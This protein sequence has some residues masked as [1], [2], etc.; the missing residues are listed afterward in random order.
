MH[1]THGLHVDRNRLEIAIRTLPTELIE[2]YLDQ[3]IRVVGRVRGITPSRVGKVRIGVSWVRGIT[4]ASVHRR[5]MTP[6]HRCDR[7]EAALATTVGSLPSP[8]VVP[9][10]TCSVAW[11]ARVSLGHHWDNSWSRSPGLSHGVAGDAGVGAC[12]SQRHG[13]CSYEPRR[14]STSGI[15]L[16]S[17]GFVDIA[18]AGRGDFSAS[19]SGRQRFWSDTGHSRA[20]YCNTDGRRI[21]IALV[22]YPLRTVSPWIRLDRSKECMFVCRITLSKAA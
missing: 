10:V 21:A 13:S 16:A 17:V 12:D 6:L 7:V 15:E 5:N 14:H 18:D 19:S 22:P 4:R 2:G 20:N 3:A 9:A 8:P 11:P 1:L